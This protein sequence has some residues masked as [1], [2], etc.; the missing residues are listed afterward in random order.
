MNVNQVDSTPKLM[1]EV[2]I[3]MALISEDHRSEANNQKWYRD[4]ESRKIIELKYRLEKLE[5]VNN[6]YQ[7]TLESFKQSSAESEKQFKAFEQAVVDLVK[8]TKP[9]SKVI[10]KLR[11]TLEPV[12]DFFGQCGST[13]PIL[14]AICGA[15]TKPRKRK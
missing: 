6:D 11:K 5:K 13:S 10:G 3:E 12:Y 4:E 2:M 9:N 15:V 8:A 7:R 1:A 14:D